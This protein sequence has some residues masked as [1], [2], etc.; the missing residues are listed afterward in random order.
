[1]K[2]RGWVGITAVVQA[3]GVF[4]LHAIVT[5]PWLLVSVLVGVA[6]CFL[7]IFPPTPNRYDS[8]VTA[9]GDFIADGD[10]EYGGSQADN[11]L[12]RLGDSDAHHD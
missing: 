12:N 2:L 4:S 7:L 11:L 3:L 8:T 5:A 10:S 6:G 9:N 1:M